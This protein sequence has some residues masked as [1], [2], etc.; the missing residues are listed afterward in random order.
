MTERQLTSLGTFTKLMRA[1]NTL[2]DR[3][4]RVVR[5]PPQL[6]GSGFAILEVL[7]HKG[8][9]CQYQISEK[10]LKTTGNISQALDKLEQK[11]LVMR[12]EGPDRR[13]FTIELTSEGHEMIV[14]AFKDMSQ[15]I[16][17][18][19]MVLEMEEQ[20]ELSRICKKLGL[21]LGRI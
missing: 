7:L 18:S 20:L 13:T 14:G 19:F 8:P 10:I 2:Q 21:G 15:A 11:G 9:L 4:K 5:L 17:E 6:A 16:E 12:L 1:T 3:L